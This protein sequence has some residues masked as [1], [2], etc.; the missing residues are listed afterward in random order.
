[1]SVIPKRITVR[2]VTAF[3]RLDT[4]RVVVSLF[5]PLQ[6]LSLPQRQLILLKTG[7]SKNGPQ[8]FKTAIGVLRQQVQTHTA[9]EAA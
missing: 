8:D 7:R 3:A 5:K 4:R 1:M 2:E 9:A 6:N